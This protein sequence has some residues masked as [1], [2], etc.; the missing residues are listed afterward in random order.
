MFERHKIGTRAIAVHVGLGRED[1]APQ[2]EAEFLELVKAS[3][4]EVVAEMKV[5]RRVPEPRYLIGEGKAEALREGVRLNGAELVIIDFAISPAQERN[6][7][8]LIECR[9]LDRIGLILDIFAQRAASFEGKLQVELAQIAS[10]FHS[11]GQ[12]VDSSRATERRYR[13]TRSRREATRDRS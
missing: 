13:I 1:D 12:R 11:A 9:V 5:N 3:G 6:L 7:E 10:S 2:L 4:A 8:R